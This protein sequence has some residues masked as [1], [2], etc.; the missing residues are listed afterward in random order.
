MAHDPRSEF[1]LD[2]TLAPTRDQDPRHRT[3]GFGVPVPEKG[4]RGWGD[5]PVPEP[6]TGPLPFTNLRGGK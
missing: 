6:L 2:L 3:P 1:A 5:L 4:D